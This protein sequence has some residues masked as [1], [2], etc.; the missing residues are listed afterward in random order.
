[1][2]VNGKALKQGD[3]IRTTRDGKSWWT[4][5]IAG[6]RYVICTRQAPFKPKGDYLYTIMDLK[7]HAQGPCNLIGNGWDVSYFKTPLHGWR[8]LHI[9]LL[10]GTIE[11]SRR[12]ACG[13]VIREV[14]I[15]A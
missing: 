2:I 11:L 9:S 13:L 12:Q 7:R 1:M 10:A 3:R 14:E 8:W 4:V 6:E 15:S 5:Q